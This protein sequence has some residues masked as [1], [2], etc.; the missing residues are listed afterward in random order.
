VIL[1]GRETLGRQ[2]RPQVA[3]AC[4]WELGRPMACLFHNAQ[5]LPHALPRPRRRSVGLI[6]RCRCD[7]RIYDRNAFLMTRKAMIPPR[8]R[9]MAMSYTMGEV[10][11]RRQIRPHVNLR[12]QRAN[13]QA[14]WMPSA[15]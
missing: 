14:G 8:A 3:N 11:L 6:P 12:C 4:Q 9:K 2:G 7:F 13:G 10:R 1:R 5:C 15:L